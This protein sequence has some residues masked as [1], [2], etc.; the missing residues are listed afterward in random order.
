MLI[1]RFDAMIVPSNV[2]SIES[3]LV[4]NGFTENLAGLVRMAHASKSTLFAQCLEVAI[5]SLA[6]AVIRHP[7]L[8]L[9]RKVLRWKNSNRHKLHACAMDLSEE[10]V[11]LIL[12]VLNDDWSTSV[13]QLSGQL[14]HYCVPGCCSS[15]LQCRAK[16]KAALRATVGSFFDVPLLYRWKHW[17]PATHFVLRNLLIHGV[18]TF[19]WEATMNKMFD[20]ESVNVTQYI[21]ADE[22]DLAPAMQQKIRMGKVWQML[23]EDTI[24]ATWTENCIVS[25]LFTARIWHAIS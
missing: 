10:S 7:L 22:A 19:I 18:L 4:L 13:K 12:S 5:D 6:S 23:G 9:P 15:D 3:A 25:K 24:I 8:E 17:D 14:N 2:Y 1:I 21:D 11:E 20:E 16:T